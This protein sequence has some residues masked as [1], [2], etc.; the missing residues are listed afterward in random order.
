MT[1]T[2]HAINRIPDAL[3]TR[4]LE[5][6]LGLVSPALLTGH[7]GDRVRGRAASGGAARS[8]PLLKLCGG[9]REARPR[10][11]FSRDS[12][13]VDG[14]YYRC[15]ECQRAY[16]V[17]PSAV[18]AARAQR[19]RWRLANPARHTAKQR[20]WVLANPERAREQQRRQ[21]DA[22]R[23][24]VR[25]QNRRRK[26]LIAVKVSYDAVY[27]R[28]RGVCYLCLRPVVRGSG[29]HFDHVVPLAAGGVHT[30][31]NIRPTHRVCNLRKGTRI[32]S[33]GA[34]AGLSQ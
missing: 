31:E 12:R 10:G 4:T 5:R 29:L 6:R 8:F 21:R 23:N 13:T 9:C 18:A 28:D 16:R 17:T 14:L 2:R 1:S 25:E 3:A 24:V 33:P 30:A 7:T 27:E 11:D 15:R 20:R 34:Y 22:K 26:A 32:V 19:R